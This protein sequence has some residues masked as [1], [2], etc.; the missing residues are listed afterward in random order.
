MNSNTNPDVPFPVRIPINDLND[1][2]AMARAEGVSL[3]S[4]ARDAVRECLDKRK[5]T[6]KNVTVKRHA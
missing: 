1:L 2:K 3:S 6:N 4:L 5:A